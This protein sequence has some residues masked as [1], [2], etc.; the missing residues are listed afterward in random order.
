M[1]NR[2]VIIAVLSFL[3]GSAFGMHSSR[4]FINADDVHGQG[5]TGL[6]V[7]VAVIDCG[8]YYD[9]PGLAGSIA[10]NGASRIL[11]TTIWDGGQDTS[12]LGTGPTCR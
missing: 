4:S 3:A 11:G 2:T 12:E 6:G 1:Y 8:I 10:P 5:I 9:H 7:T